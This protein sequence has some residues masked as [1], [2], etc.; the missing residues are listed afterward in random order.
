MVIQTARPSMFFKQKAQPRS[1]DPCREAPG[2]KWLTN[3]R[4]FPVNLWI[5]LGLSLVKDRIWR[6]I[7]IQLLQKDAQRQVAVSLHIMT[8]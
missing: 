8:S 3:F 1:E 2:S 6:V 5:H 4:V 7:Y